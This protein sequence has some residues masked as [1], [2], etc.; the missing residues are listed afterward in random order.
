[1]MKKAV[2]YMRARKYFLGGII[3]IDV[4]NHPTF[5]IFINT[6]C[7]RISNHLKQKHAHVLLEHRDELQKI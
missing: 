3:V 1:M 7:G 5:E 4:C 2:E 6:L